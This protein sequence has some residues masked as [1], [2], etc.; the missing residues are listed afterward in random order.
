VTRRTEAGIGEP[1]HNDLDRVLIEYATK[2][3][4]AVLLLWVR[5]ARHLKY[6]GD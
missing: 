4:K 6:L 1:L 2:G 5:H 3:F